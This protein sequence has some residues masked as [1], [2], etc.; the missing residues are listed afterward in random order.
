MSVDGIAVRLEALVLSVN[1]SALS[2]IQISDCSEHE[3]E[4]VLALCP[5]SIST[6]L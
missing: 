2:A 1:S 4:L 6:D 5:F 3:K